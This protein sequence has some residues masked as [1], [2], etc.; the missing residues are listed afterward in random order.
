MIDKRN[1]DDDVSG[2]GTLRHTA[3]ETLSKTSDT[4]PELKDKDIERDHSR[5]P[6]PSD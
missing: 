6:G 2:P 3:E 4:M 1:L 5:T